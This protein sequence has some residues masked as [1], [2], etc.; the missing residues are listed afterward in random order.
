MRSCGDFLSRHTFGEGDIRA[1]F[2]SPF[3]RG[4]DPTAVRTKRQLV[5]ID[6]QLGDI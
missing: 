1:S 6:A 5:L 2:H 3:H 4:N